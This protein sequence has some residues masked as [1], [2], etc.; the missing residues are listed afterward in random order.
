MRPRLDAQ[1]GFARR[2]VRLRR[3]SARGGCAQRQQ[4]HQREGK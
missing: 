3:R 2:L 1:D 4:G